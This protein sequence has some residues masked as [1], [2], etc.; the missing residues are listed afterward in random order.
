VASIQARSI[1]LCA[2]YPP[3]D[4]K[5]RADSHE[6]AAAVTA[7]I[8]AAFERDWSIVFGGHP[9]IVPLVFMVAREL[10]RKGI[11]T[12][13]Q[14]NYFVNHLSR[15]AG[16][17]AE[18]GYGEI[19]LV[20]HDP[21]EIPPAEGEPVDARR[22]PRSL[23]RMR[24]VMVSHPGSQAL[25]VIGGDT[26]VLDEYEIFRRANPL[27]PAIPIGFP[28][29]AAREL[30]ALMNVPGM[31]EKLK[32]DLYQSSNYLSLGAQIMKYLSGNRSS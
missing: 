31:G 30:G 18:Q 19:V 22:C 8:S 4:Y 14:S 5:L 1:I 10:D 16:S 21:G 20:P 17:L 15:A 24:E 6:I 28:G 2:S 3:R 13:Y 27:L 7:L 9:S 23:A 12:I 26:G 29:G 11:V 25:V 32:V